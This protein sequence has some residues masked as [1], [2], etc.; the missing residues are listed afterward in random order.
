M[1]PDQQVLSEIQAHL[2]EPENGGAAWSSGMWTV[3]EVIALLGAREQRFLQETEVLLDTA[4]VNGAP[5]MHRVVLPA[6]VSRVQDVAFERADGT[7]HPLSRS[8]SF[9]ADHALPAWEHTQFDYPLVFSELQ[10]PQLELAVVPA[11]A[12][13]GVFHL[14]FVAIATAVTGAGAVFTVPDLFLPG[15]KWGTI[16]DML[17]KVGEA[18]DPARAA[19]AE[20]R[21]LQ[22][23]EAARLLLEG[24]DPLG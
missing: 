23:V 2:I 5:N 13:A 21:Y 14:Y 8:D 4:Q 9:A 22:W 11:Q 17:S 6:T 3:A 7:F 10:T 20:Q 15:V 18:Q 1:T 12:D 16:A 24:F 19:Y